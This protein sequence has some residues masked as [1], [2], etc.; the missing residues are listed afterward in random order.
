MKNLLVLIFTLSTLI[1]N[2]QIERFSMLELYSSTLQNSAEYKP[3]CINFDHNYTVASMLPSK[4]S[5]Y[6]PEQ[7]GGNMKVTNI[8]ENN[9]AVLW[10]LDFIGTVFPYQIVY[11]NNTHFVVGIF[12][13]SIS[14]NGNTHLALDSNRVFSFVAAINS[15]GQLKWLKIMEDTVWNSMAT[16]VCFLPSGNLLVTALYHDVESVVWKLDP[17]TGDIISAKIFPGVR[18]FSDIKYNNDKIYLTGSTGDFSMIDSFQ[19]LN[20]LGNGYVNFLCL[21]DTNLSVSNLYYDPYIT[22]DFSSQLTL[23]NN[24]VMWAHYELDSN[25]GVV[26]N[27][28]YFTEAGT[29]YYKHSFF[30]NMNLSE[31]D[32]RLIY[33][34]NFGGDFVF[35]KKI[36]KDYYLFDLGNMYRDSIQISK[37]SKF[38]IYDL[39]IK[40]SEFVLVGMFAADTLNYLGMEFLNP[41]T[42]TNQT[43]AFISKIVET[44]SG[45]GNN[46][47]KTF[48]LFPNPSEHT[49]NI[50]LENVEMVEVIDFTG[51]VNSTHYLTNTIPIEELSNGMYLLKVSTQEGVYTMKFIKK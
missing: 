35:I 6:F 7:R 10:N 37:D 4:Y 21:A 19:V 38:T 3:V 39:S 32:N 17:N 42:G 49:I 20:P 50:K 12:T 24:G 30:T 16:S 40:N 2:A 18:T 23:H 8:N 43:V 28:S 15:N 46:N 48:S 5:A 27:L 11:A 9:N 1:S 29:M 41:N 33:P 31:F 13:D 45:I 34:K 36:D 44:N 47:S 26:Q 51:K 22:F 25:I 14:V